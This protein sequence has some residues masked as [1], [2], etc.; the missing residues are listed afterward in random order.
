MTVK[1]CYE[2]AVALVPETL[3]ENPE[4][5]K[6]AVPW[7]NILLAE[8]LPY[9]NAYRRIKKLPEI[10]AAPKVFKE[11]EEIPFNENMVRAAFPYGMAR[12]IFRE[13]EDISGSHEYYQLY[14]IA[15]MEAVPLEFTEIEDFYA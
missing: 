3:E 7:C 2:Q 10:E 8:T 15:L 13:N 5:R 14:S 12:W 1:E 9:E 11:D 6:F 4:M